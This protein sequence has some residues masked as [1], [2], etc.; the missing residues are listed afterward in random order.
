M[1]RERSGLILKCSEIFLSFHFVFNI[2]RAVSPAPSPLYY[3]YVT[4]CVVKIQPLIHSWCPNS[5]GTGGMAS[6][7]WY[8][9][10]INAS[11]SQF[12][13]SRNSPNY[14]RNSQT[15]LRYVRKIFGSSNF[16]APDKTYGLCRQLTSFLTIFDTWSNAA[17]NNTI[18]SV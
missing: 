2:E 12:K 13:D 7:I 10:F 18:C 1:A 16:P 17:Q 5:G 15:V 6:Q 8:S 3:S 4:T 14:S 9:L 11:F